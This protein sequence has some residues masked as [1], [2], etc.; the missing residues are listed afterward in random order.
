MSE[1]QYEEL[2]ML[3]V[4]TRDIVEQ[5]ITRIIPNLADQ[6]TTGMGARAA[7]GCPG[8]QGG[9]PGDAYERTV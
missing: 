3:V 4:Q 8:D 7:D 5:L 2:K 9:L 6:L 1:D